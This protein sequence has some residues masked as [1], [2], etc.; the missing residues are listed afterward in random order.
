[1]TARD[2]TAL[3]L[4][5]RLLG[6]LTVLRDGQAVALPAS[7]KARALLGYLA[8]AP[9]PVTR[10]QLC[11]LL[12][13]G[14]NDPRG[15]LRW[16]LSRLRAAIDRP[17]QDKTGQ[18][19]FETRDDTLRLRLEDGMVD[20]VD[21]ASAIRRGPKTLPLD[22]LR[23]L[24]GLFAGD[25][26]EG[27]DADRN[28][29]FQ[30]W[31]TAQRRRLRG[32]HTAL[33]EEIVAQSDDRS[34]LPYLDQWQRITP[35]DL[36]VHEMLLQALV[37]QGRFRE[38]EEHLT[39]ATR[40]FE[41][42]DLD[43]R[44]L[45]MAW[46]AA[47]MRNTTELHVEAGLTRPAEPPAQAPQDRPT[48]RA[49]IAVM[50]FAD[51]TAAG[52][53]DWLTT[54]VVVR[55]A[56]LR[57]LLVIS[58]GT[59]LTLRDRWIAPDEAA[60]LLNVDYLVNGALRRQNG[61]ISVTVEL[62]DTRSAR[63]LWTEVFS[64]NANDALQVFD[65]IGSRIAD[66]ISQEV[67]ASE[68]NR[69]ILKNPNSL[70][71]W[72][73]YHRGM[74]HFYRFDREENRRAQQFFR[75]ALQLDP[76]FSRAHAGLSFTHYQNAFQGWADRATESEHAY[77]TASQGMLVDER[78][79]AVREVMGRALWLRGR[80]DHALAELETAIDLSPNFVPGHYTLSFI[81]CLAGDPRAA[82]AASDHS[83][84]ISPFDPLLFAMLAS[85]AVALLRLGRF[86]EA[87]DW[88][89]RAA[90]QP[91]AHTHVQALTAYALALAGRVGEARV[92]MARIRES[93]PGY[94]VETYLSAMRLA[95]EGAAA[96]RRIAPRL[97]D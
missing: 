19:R 94:G 58:Q 39:T 36:R 12:W 71:A 89:L 1:M 62:S 69:A 30:S 35:F 17:C 22:E 61:R 28:P 5:L 84:R 91:N 93:W 14:P 63:I 97:E 74:W 55:L 86:D 29:A 18:S 66:R 10:S 59:T 34:A 90:M 95:P 82:I 80:Q 87:A 40:L 7:R 54:D 44:P 15:E 83:R 3:A 4:Q 64:R 81:H 85:R 96:V 31:L 73:A 24:A 41:S 60:R 11:D 57:S 25:F 88:S 49:A 43:H 27:L 72:E 48:R 47:R 26:L 32:Y 56:R 77:A 23:R 37:R 8:L 78:D 9:Q 79:P 45:R 67:E 38:G 16:C 68:R 6:P 50:P 70:D 21:V 53:A 2:E 46:Q 92:A 52:T 65:E 51:S 20:A 13:D 33:L 75:Q 42:E 76:T